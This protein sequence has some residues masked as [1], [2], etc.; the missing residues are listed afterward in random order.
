MAE[1]QR[2]LAGVPLQ[3]LGEI[4]VRSRPA[5]VQD[6]EKADRRRDHANRRKNG[7]DP[8]SGAAMR[9][10]NGG[11]HGAV[12]QP[13]PEQDRGPGQ[14]GQDV[15]LLP[16]GK[17]KEERNEG[18]PDHQQKTAAAIQREIVTAK[19]AAPSPRAQGN[20]PACRFKGKRGPRHQPH[21]AQPPE[22]R[23]RH[24]VVVVRDAQV[25][26]A[27]QVFVHEVKPR[28]TADIA[29]RGQR[30]LPVS[31]GQHGARVLHEGEGRGM[32]LR[33]VGQAR[34]QMPRR[35]DREKHQEGAD[36]MQEAEP[37]ESASKSPRQQQIH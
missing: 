27:E 8:A 19:L 12:R 5:G 10:G 35:G 25:Q 17:R 20:G 1:A 14:G 6:E 18:R 11:V 15:V 28:P 31:P 36:R 29:V 33:G 4:G 23:Q 7:G 13:S 22:Q 16:R 34:R 26:V 21:Q 2:V 3:Q 30:H 24:G 37:V 9:V 32:A